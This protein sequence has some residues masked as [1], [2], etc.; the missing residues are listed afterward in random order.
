MTEMKRVD[1]SIGTLS[2]TDSLKAWEA[3]NDSQQSFLE[4]SKADDD[5]G[6]T[7]PSSDE[8]GKLCWADIDFCERLGSGTFSDVYSVR[9]VNRDN[10]PVANLAPRHKPS[11]ALKCV[12]VESPK[13]IDHDFIPNSV[14]LATEAAI[15]S[16]LDHKNIIRVLGSNDSTDLQAHK[17]YFFIMEILET[18][19]SARLEQ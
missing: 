19:L 17:G 6:N 1:I 7:I 15:L 14:N 2:C 11:H 10:T 9:V 12:R 5:E 18:T 16:T 4:V 13:N 3:M 8:T